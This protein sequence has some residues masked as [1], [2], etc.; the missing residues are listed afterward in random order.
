M[1]M[2]LGG[3]WVDAADGKTIDV[4]NPYNGE[5]IDT[6]P[7]A[8]KEDVDKAVA[9]AKAAQKEWVK[10]PT[11]QRAALMKKFAALMDEHMDEL[12]NILSEEVG[13]PLGGAA[14]ELGCV[15]DTCIGFAEKFCHI[16]DEIIPA[17]SEAGTEK[18]L[19]ITKRVPLGVIACVA[20]F[21][22]P[23]WSFCTKIGPA[24]IAG[25]TA[26]MK[27]ASNAPLTLLKL[28]E[29][30]DKAGVPAGVFQT[31]TGSGGAIGT[32]LCEHEGV[33]GIT[34]TG[35]TEVGVKTAHA[36]AEHLAHV[37]LELGGNDGC[38]VMDD[39]DLELAASEI[40][41]SRMSNNGQVC[42]VPKRI[43]A[44]KGIKDELT[45]KIVEKVKALKHGDPKEP[46]TTITCLIDEAA[47][48]KVEEQVNKT[49]A[50][51]ATLLLG[52]ERQGTY[53]APTVLTDVTMDM[54]VA[55]DMEIFGP[56]IPII[57]V[58][59]YEEAIAGANA[60]KY[61]LQ[62]AIF[63]TDVKTA[64]RAAQDYEAGAVVING[65][66]YFSTVEMAFGGSKMSGIGREGGC[67]S[68]EEVTEY[69][70]IVLKNFLP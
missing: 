6:V 62:A 47:A 66:S 43:F 54:D 61:G 41:G 65:H 27:P 22:F 37:T 18:T 8:T 17:G 48:K 26:I 57:E 9:C 42:S 1:K 49:I 63:T 68:I 46:G 33:S 69:K 35:S 38:I 2:F 7:A 67:C 16:Y 31:I 19:L 25:N 21:N 70:T 12:V 29:L 32:Y 45:A 4:F 24:L 55:T 44:Q 34:L 14:G 39:A 58:A 10:V 23:A 64:I 11:Y 30:M 5:L 3:E 40:V 15:R 56:V 51:G 52:G 53:Y 13:K 60:S 50:Q 36:A 20:P 28:A 59:D